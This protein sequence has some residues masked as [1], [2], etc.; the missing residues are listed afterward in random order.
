MSSKGVLVV[1]SVVIILFAVVAISYTK[2]KDRAMPVVSAAPRENIQL[3]K[4]QVTP[5]HQDEK[6]KV[7][8][9]S[10]KQDVPRIM[11]QAGDYRPPVQQKDEGLKPDPR[12]AVAPVQWQEEPSQEGAKKQKGYLEMPGGGWVFLGENRR[13]IVPGIIINRAGE[14]EFFAITQGGKDYE[15][16]MMLFCDVVK[17]RLALTSCKLKAGHIPTRMDIS[18]KNQGDRIIVLVQWKEQGGVIKTYRAEDLVLDRAQDGPM[19]RVGFTYTGSYFIDEIDPDTNKPTGR[20]SFAAN[21]FKTVIT[22]IR[23]ESALLDNPLPEAIDHIGIL[24]NW[25]VLP[26]AGTQIKVIFKPATQDEKEEIGKLEKK[27]NG[28]K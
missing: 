9:N 14:M 2:L 25:S 20:T 10:H 7:P 28:A 17:L 27:L 23:D 21:I 3:P 19:P 4:V 5:A 26:P 12:Y 8:A 11:G 24:A 15:S 22:T 6:V 16:V 18:D 13:V 1:A